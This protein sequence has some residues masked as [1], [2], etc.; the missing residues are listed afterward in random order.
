LEA[1]QR[2]TGALSLRLLRFKSRRLQALRSLL[3]PFKV[4]RISALIKEIRP[5]AVIVSQ[6]RI[7]SSSLGL[8]A[9]KRAGSRTIS[10]IPLAHHVAVSGKPG[11]AN[12]REAINR[13]YYRLPDKFITISEGM[14]KM[15]LDRGA[16]PNISVVHNCVEEISIQDSDRKAFREAHGFS[17]SDFVVAVLGRIEFGQKGQDFALR[18]IARFREKLNHCKFLFIGGGP[19]E[20]KLRAMTTAMTLEPWVRTL[21]WTYSTARVYAGIDMLLIPSR[22]EGVPLVMLEAMSCGL[23]IVASD[24]DGMSEFLPKEWLFPCGSEQDLVDTVL[25]VKSCEVSEILRANRTLVSQKCSA[26]DFGVQFA[27]AILETIGS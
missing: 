2:T 20:G 10:Y 19:D 5:N 6:G 1:L 16:R 7:E 9:A 25:R 15:L 18:A 24:I 8:L 27:N 23:R 22:F 13:Y 11:G 17:D 14:R 26:A 21:P 3:S 4:R 12:V